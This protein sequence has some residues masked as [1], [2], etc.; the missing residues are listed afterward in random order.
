[1]L[2]PSC[3]SSNNGLQLR[4][5]IIYTYTQYYTYFIVALK[6]Q[7][8]AIFYTMHSA[9]SDRHIIGLVNYCT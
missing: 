8:Y 5:I 1:M 7:L 4:M 3:P 2:L 6:R 9:T